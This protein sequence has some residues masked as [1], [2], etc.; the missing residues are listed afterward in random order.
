MKFRRTYKKIGKSRT[1]T[2]QFADKSYV[3]VYAAISRQLAPWR[4]GVDHKIHAFLTS[5]TASST[6]RFNLGTAWMEG[7][8]GSRAGFDCLTEDHLFLSPAA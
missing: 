4:G 8:V 6:D 3:L 5:T 1:K 2:S 7:H